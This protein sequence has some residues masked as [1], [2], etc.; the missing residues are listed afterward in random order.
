MVPAILDALST[1][2]YAAVTEVVPDEADPYCARAAKENGGIV[3]TSDSDM[4]VYDLGERGAVTFLNGLEL[5]QPSYGSA[6]SC[7]CGKIMASICR[8]SD[9]MRRL[10]V[11]SFQRVCFEIKEDPSIT[12]PTALKLAK[13]PVTKPQKLQ[14]FLEQYNTS[15]LTPVPS[16]QSSAQKKH[17]LDPQTSD[18]LLQ[19]AISP[20]QSLHI[21]LLTLFDDPS[22]T[23]AWS[24]SDPL[25]LIAFAYA[26]ST[27]LDHY[28]HRD[29]VLE[30]S[31]RGTR[32][33]A[34]NISILSDAESIAYAISLSE[35]IQMLR[36][37]FPDLLVALRWRL[38]ALHEILTWYDYF[39]KKPPSTDILVRALTG[40]ASKLWGWEDV[41]FEAQVQGI[42]YSLRVFGQVLR[43]ISPEARFK[44]HVVF[45]DLSGILEELPPL[46]E[47]LPSRLGLALQVPRDFNGE[48]VLNALITM[49]R[50]RSGDIEPEDDRLVQTV[51]EEA[52]WEH[53][54]QPK[55]SGKKIKG[56]RKREEEKIKQAGGINPF[57]VLE[58]A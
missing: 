23:S 1:S 11:E 38:F 12:F 10:N 44:D 21:Y 16:P 28:H 26:S 9:L 33:V 37:A 5:L 22:K 35:R 24:P 41:H 7:L 42:L 53:Q 29:P 48:G 4:L 45:Q 8:P 57:S 55:K 14:H 3:L 15:S 56:E 46:A 30:H 32:I 31:R 58:Y 54:K 19:T 13:L 36:N 20:D 49:F 6:E 34:E 18:L 52:Q 27:S 43:R 50:A 40:T 39:S 25:R 17:F 2:V 47:V 51:R